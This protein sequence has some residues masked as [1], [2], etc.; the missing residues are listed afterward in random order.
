MPSALIHLVTGKKF[1][2]DAG[3][4]FLVGTLAP[5][6]IKERQEKDLLHFR[7]SEDRRADLL[8][9][10]KRYGTKDEFLLGVIL[11][12]YTDL[13]WDEGP[14]TKHK[15]SYTGET[16]FKDYRQEIN[17]ASC[18]IYHNC[19]GSKEMWE[20][21]MDCPESSYASAPEYPPEKI[22]AYLEHSYEYISTHEIGP[23]AAFPPNEV[24]L[25]CARCAAEFAEW[26]KTNI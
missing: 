16:W 8:S 9:L 14:Q 6:C 15:N 10:L 13:C 1:L 12:L 2:P 11:H 5:D 7:L 18:Y 3:A 26:L 19:Q 20:K 23:S 17:L 22:R 21:I 4:A 24:E 25:F